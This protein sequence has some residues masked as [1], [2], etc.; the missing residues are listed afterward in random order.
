MEETLTPTKTIV[1]PPRT[2]WG[3]RDF[4][5]LLMGVLLPAATVLIEWTTHFCA[6]M[7]FNPIPTHWHALAAMAVPVSN[8]LLL[9]A[10]HRSRNE[11][12]WDHLLSLIN[13]F[14]IGIAL[15]YA[16]V[17]LPLSVLGVFAIVLLGMGFLPLAPLFSLITA[18]ALRIRWWRNGRKGGFPMVAGGMLL[19]G[20]VII[21]VQWS[22]S[23]T[24][25]GLNL[26]ASK[27][28][29]RA[30]RGLSMLRNWGDEDVMLEACYRPPGER[31]DVLAHVIARDLSP[32]GARKIFYRATGKAFNS[33]PPPKMVAND[34]MFRDFAWDEDLASSQVGAQVRGVSLASSRIDGNLDGDAAHAYLEWTMEFANAS[35]MNRE[36]RM[37]MA[38]PH[39]AVV[40]RLTLWVN[41]EEREAAFG[42]R[43]QVRQAYTGVVQQRRDPVLVTTAG[44][45]RVQVQCFPIPPSGNMKI[46]VGITAPLQI[47]TGK[48][49][50]FVMPA[51]VERNFTVATVKHSV[52]LE[53]KATLLTDANATLTERSAAGTFTARGDWDDM[54]LSARPTVIVERNPASTKLDVSTPRGQVVQEIKPTT[55]PGAGAVVIVIDDSASMRNVGERVR[56][57]LTL[58]M[59][60][61]VLI[62][63]DEVTTMGSADPRYLGGADNVPALIAAWD[64]LATTSGGV[65]I[66]LHGPQPE[67]F[68]DPGTLRQRLERRPDGPR[69]ISM[70]V[71]PGPNRVVQAL[72]GLAA[73]E[74]D[75]VIPAA[76]YQLN[77]AIA[78]HIEAGERL[79]ITRKLL[80]GSAT[81]PAGRGSH[82][83]RLW[84]A[85]RVAELMRLTP[86]KI[87]AAAAVAYEYKIVTPV[88]GAVVLE[89]QQQFAQAGLQPVDPAN[90]PIVPEPNS[91]GVIVAAITSRLLS[92]R[93]RRGPPARMR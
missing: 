88:S 8:L 92:R 22:L 27:D 2:R 65:I 36:A 32:E 23:V 39:G 35:P 55:Q 61:T 74:S 3:L 85:D 18:V 14:A 84:A 81:G 73:V 40:S 60:S 37:Q 68:A 93:R 83:A 10:L 42:K 5:L 16:L 56:G 33:L 11:S 69:L 50:S 7:F 91:I 17:F 63:G 25:I 72:D 86:P 34:G 46:R 26:A 67:I 64:K 47:D 66:W 57:Q 82:V 54:A 79:T 59:G 41:G 29:A 45:D 51:I 76:A 70:Q 89:T 15:F 19:A 21:A 75:P 28:P 53:G 48:L 31:D 4:T 44:P 20:I 52:W 13:G 87:D 49:A 71:A 30:A 62:A 12:R 9:L 77:A 90:V 1:I 38:L 78:R 58:P 24:T 80:D 6:G 43:A